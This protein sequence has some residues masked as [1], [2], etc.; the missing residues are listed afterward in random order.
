MIG[1]PG[2]EPL[3]QQAQETMPH[4]ASMLRKGDGLEATLRA[5][6][7][8]IASGFVNGTQI[9]G[10]GPSVCLAKPLGISPGH[11]ETRVF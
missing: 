1:S 8:G 11:S 10:S 5:V 9:F 6:V 2:A 4:G 3:E 7:E